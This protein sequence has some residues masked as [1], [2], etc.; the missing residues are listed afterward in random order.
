MRP[1]AKT[2]GQH[3]ERTA[4]MGYNGLQSVQNMLSEVNSGPT[5]KAD[6][7]PDL[8]RG[9]NHGIRSRPPSRL[10]QLSGISRWKK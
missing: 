3:E 6:T 7:S 5:A 4:A 10:S 1:E 2:R 9:S 8:S